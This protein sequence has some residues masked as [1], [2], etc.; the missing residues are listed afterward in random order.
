MLPLLL[1]M[2]LPVVPSS[3]RLLGGT[4]RQRPCRLGLPPLLQLRRRCLARKQRQAALAHRAQQLPPRNKLQQVWAV[5]RGSL[6]CFKGIRQR[7][8]AEIL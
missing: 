5:G 8:A 6:I 1:L 4:C 2:P 7:A 3:R